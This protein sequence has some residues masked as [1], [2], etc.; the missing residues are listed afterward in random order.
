MPDMRILAVEELENIYWI[1]LAS[2][3]AFSQRKRP[4]RCTDAPMTT[5]EE[6]II[7]LCKFTLPVIDSR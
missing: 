3:G 5:Q 4:M 6:L 7:A 2:G 1:P